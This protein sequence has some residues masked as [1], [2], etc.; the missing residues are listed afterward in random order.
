MNVQNHATPRNRLSLPFG[1]P[2]NSGMSQI[3][4][5]T[6]SGRELRKIVADMLG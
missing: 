3:R 2:S 6:L 1:T 4:P 5:A